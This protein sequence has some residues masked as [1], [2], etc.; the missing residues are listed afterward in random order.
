MHRIEKQE[1]IIGLLEREKEVLKGSKVSESSQSE[2]F[3]IWFL[4]IFD[5]I[6]SI[7]IKEVYLEQQRVKVE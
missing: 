4:I 3:T 7:W 2:T 5:E 6:M 1:M